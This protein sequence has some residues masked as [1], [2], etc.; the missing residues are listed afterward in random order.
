MKKI[1]ISIGLVVGL[2]VASG[3]AVTNIGH[4]ADFRSG[5][6]PNV[7]TNEVIESSLYTAGNDIT[8][9]GT[10]NGDVFC[11]GMNVDITGT[12][13]GDVLC[14]AQTI[15]ISGKVL[16]SVRAA[17]QQI[18]VDG[19]IEGSASLAGQAVTLDS[20][21]KIGR[22]LTV[23]GQ[24]L[25]LNGQVARDVVGGSQDMTVNG[26]IGR[27]VH[28]GVENLTLG[29]GAKINGDLTY[30][31][32]NDV[33]VD[34]GA[35]VT[36]KTLRKEAPRAQRV[37]TTVAAFW[38][39]LFSFGS[40][41]LIGF[42]AV[43][44]APRAMD[45]LGQ[46]IRKRW[47]LSLAGGAAALFLL[48]FVAILLLVSV[49]GIPLAAIMILLWVVGLITANIITSYAIGWMIVE[50]I[51]WPPRGKRFTSLLVGLLVLTLLEW[52]PFIG[53][54]VGFVSLVFGL[55]S[56]AVTFGRHLQTQRIAKPS[57]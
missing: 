10:V 38:I 50:Q 8:V 47:M 2:G 11:A 52:I 12:V 18:S 1:L 56:L 9:S 30:T 39:A 57:R 46:V 25:R 5:Q 19:N 23:G 14:V 6:S 20:A 28:I 24:L 36:G 48:P 51:K 26:L 33:V 27:D 40:M 54:L 49:V 53:P 45:A 44:L 29:S 31:S 17:G 15:K 7:S 21:A 55:G 16:G 37:N 22:D 35:V 34:A 3:L 4:A 43:A 13:N 41:L 32:N 42:V